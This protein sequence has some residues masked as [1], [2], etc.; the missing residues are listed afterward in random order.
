MAARRGGAEK[1]GTKDEDAAAFYR[2][3]LS[4]GEALATLAVLRALDQVTTSNSLAGTD[5][6][7]GILAAAAQ[8]LSEE[9]PDFTVGRA[10]RLA[11]ALVRTLRETVAVSADE[12]AAEIR[13]A[14]PF[15]IRRN[16][17]L[18]EDAYEERQPVEIEYYVSGRKEWT[19]RRVDISS[20][21]AQNGTWYLSGQCGLR[22]DHRQFRL[23]HI[24]FVRVLDDANDTPD[25]F[26]E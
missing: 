24:R 16:R 18:L 10:E 26:T 11:A 20:V 5:I 3:P 13:D 6:E 8:R 19:H 21:H 23:D 17:R 25:P 4:S 14:P 15:P 7:P 1:N 22:S 12:D 2:I 9:L